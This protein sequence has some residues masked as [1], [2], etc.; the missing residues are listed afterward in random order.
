MCIIQLVNWGVEPCDFGAKQRNLEEEL[1]TH[2]GEVPVS[3]FRHLY[4]EEF[5]INFA[6]SYVLQNVLDAEP[7]HSI[8]QA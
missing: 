8:S 6:P 4:G 2:F 5:A 7:E 1:R 3:I